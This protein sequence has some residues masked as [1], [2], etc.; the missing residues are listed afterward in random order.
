MRKL[1]ALIMAVAAIPGLAMASAQGPSV[2][3]QPQTSIAAPIGDVEP[4]S[5]VV[6]VAVAPTTIPAGQTLPEHVSPTER[7]VY[8]VSGRV[9]VTNLVTG[10]GQDVSPGEM[11][12][13]TQGH[14]HVAAALDGLP[15]S[16]LLIDGATLGLGQR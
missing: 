3:T 15:A 10:E 4:A 1:T 2:K 12:V 9:R 14:L 6:R 7:Y 13:E 11:A 8:V 16:V 5:G